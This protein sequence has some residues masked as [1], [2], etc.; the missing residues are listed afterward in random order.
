MI[1]TMSKKY[2]PQT[3]FRFLWHFVKQQKLVFCLMF[4]TALVWSINETFFPYFIKLIVNAAHHFKGDPSEIFA[5]AKWPVISLIIIWL[6]MELSMRLQGIVNIYAFPRFR[7]NITEGV[8]DYVKQHSHRYFSNQFI[9][10][11]SNKLGS[12]PRSSQTILEILIFNLVSIIVAFIIGLVLMWLASPLFTFIMLGWF[13]VHTGISV[14]FLKKANILWEE[15]AES[16]TTLGGKIADSL[17]NMMNVRLFSRAHYESHYLKKFQNDE[18]KKSH[19]ASLYIEKMRILQGIAGCLLIFAMIFTLLY[20]WSKGWVT[21]GDFSLI[22][23]L[24]FGQLG[25]V[26]YMSYQMTVFIRELSTIKD[27]LS[28]IATH[29]EVVDAPCANNLKITQGE[30]HFD[31]VSFGYQP[32]KKIFN[33]LNLTIPAGQKMGLVG[34][35]GA[36]K[37]TLVQL[38]L[39]FY[40][41]DAG[42]I[43]IDNQNIAEVTQ[44]SLREQIAMIPQDPV[45]FHRSLMEN[46]RYGRVDASDDEVIAASKLAHCHEFIMQLTQGYNTLVGERGIKLSGGQRQRIAIARAILK[47]APILILDEA[48]SSLDSI[49]EKFIQ[50]SLLY[51]MKNRTTIVIAHRL[52]TLAT[53]DRIIVFENGKV[54]EDGTIQLLLTTNGHFAKLWNMQIDGFLPDSAKECESV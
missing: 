47:N 5:A 40:D 52:S 37:S 3:A 46:I 13:I 18:I 28:L 39:R 36:G 30:I 24:S 44:A 19:K 17:A 4:I 50:E 33:Q 26:W 43:L 20:R 7:A 9:G 10:S 27:A 49:T 41:L 22:A 16:V 38:I 29:H 31:N 32:H 14:L 2:L 25:M 34:F 8:Y 35:S 1:S 21:L 6:V 51:L 11:L 23:M 54:T 53:M 48:T 42:R 45:L 15:H 12:L